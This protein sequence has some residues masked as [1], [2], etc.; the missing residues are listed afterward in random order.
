MLVYKTGKFRMIG[1]TLTYGN[2]V[3]MA[4]I[5]FDL[6][7]PYDVVGVELQTMTAAYT[8]PHRINLPLLASLIQSDSVKTLCN[9]DAEQFPAVQILLWKPIH[10]NV[11]A[12]GKVILLGLKSTAKADEIIAA[13]VTKL[14]SS[15]CM[16]C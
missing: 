10:V 7:S 3:G 9:Y 1:K 2:A 14:S 5:V 4:A 6:V 13:L 15:V 8:H 11:F 16:T 12:S